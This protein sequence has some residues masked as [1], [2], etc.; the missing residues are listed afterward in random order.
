[1]SPPSA[2]GDLNSH[3]E[4]FSFKVTAHSGDAAHRT[5]SVYTKCEVRNAWKIWLIFGHGVK[6]SGDLDL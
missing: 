2:S 3:P 4:L 5:P 1:M 6:R